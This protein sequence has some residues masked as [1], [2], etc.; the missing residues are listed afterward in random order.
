MGVQNIIDGDGVGL[1]IT[2]M[3]IVFSGLVF[4]SLFISAL[5]R[6]IA[7]AD[8]RTERR[9]N[10]SVPESA[11]TAVDGLDNPALRAAIALVIQL[12]ID[13]NHVLDAQ[14]ITMER[15]EA[16]VVWALAGKMRTLSKRM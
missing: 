11:R 15:D 13:S 1:A 9:V 16:Q 6:V 3:L 7:W 5:P 4:I 2:G 12:E 14:R 8:A 10:R